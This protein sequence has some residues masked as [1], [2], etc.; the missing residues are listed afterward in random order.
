M[1]NKRYLFLGFICFLVMQ[2][3]ASIKEYPVTKKVL[4][5]DLLHGVEVEDPYRWL[6]DFTSEEVETWV[7]LQNNLSKRYLKRNK[8]KK[9]IKENLES[10]WVSE[11]K[12]IPQIRGDAIFYFFNDGSWEQSKL[13]KQDCIDC[14]PEVTI[15]PNTFSNDG[16]VSLSNLSISPNGKFI[17]YSISDGGSDWKT[18]KVLDVGSSQVLEN[19]IEWT[20]FSSGSWEAD[21][22]GFY[23]QKYPEPKEV[24]LSEINKSPKLYFHKIGTTQR[25]DVL[26]YDQPDKPNW[27]WNI[28]ASEDGKYRILYVGEGTDDSNKLYLQFGKDQSFVP[29]VAELEASYIFLGN[30]GNDLWFFTN[31][32]APNGKIV[33]LNIIKNKSFLWEDVINET[34]LAISGFSLINNKFVIEYLKDSQ[35]KVSFYDLKGEFLSGL[36]LPSNGSVS[37]FNGKISDRYTY[38]SFTN[39]VTPTRIYKMDMETL[40]FEEYWEESLPN[41]NSSDYFTELRFFN[42]KDGTKVPLHITY[43]KD[44]LIKAD[45]PVLLYGYGGFNISI[46][47]SF[48]KTYLAWMNQGGVVAV[49]N[50]RGGSE[51][52]DAWHEAGMLLNKQNVFDDFAYAAKFLHSENIGSSKST[53]IQGRSNGGLLVGATML[54]NPSLFAV[55]IPQVGVMDMLRFSKFTI[56]WAWESDYGSVED[57]Q[58]FF[59]LL[60]YS[61]YHNIKAGI[62]YPPTLITTANRD[63]RVVPSH[64]FKFAARLQELQGCDNPVLLR[65]ETR[66]GHG[67]GTPRN[68]RIE[69]IADIY[70]MHCLLSKKE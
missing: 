56:G 70:G 51:Y 19:S 3:C 25:E 28:E 42:S 13:M 8:Y 48:S 67:S 20:K 16:T 68:K 29:V 9:R 58:A 31:K 64:S 35:S 24:A 26:I 11:S 40:V 30:K 61:P 7:G 22:S 69:E 10:I 55:T 46:L 66:A 6:E 39:Y 32:N 62:C 33:K 5:V 17:A 44:T 49:A 43:K 38:F 54:Q 53:V 52:G 12:S 50:L 27:S 18:W 57:R 1:K 65:V 45:T 4:Q 41:F 36:N 21:S 60:S 14:S 47:P 59:N 34:T 15:D 37:G 23:Y 63:D 2:S